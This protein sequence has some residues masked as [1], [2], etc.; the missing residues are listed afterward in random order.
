MISN[1][2]IFVCVYVCVCMY[3]CVHMYVCVF[4]YM[5]LLIINYNKIENILLKLFVNKIIVD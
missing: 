1:I 3:V 2:C 4:R 5:C